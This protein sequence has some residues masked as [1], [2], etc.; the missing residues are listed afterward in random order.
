MENVS[1][2]KAKPLQSMKQ[3]YLNYLPAAIYTVHIKKIDNTSHSGSTE[4]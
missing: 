1:N 2:L 3:M 4:F